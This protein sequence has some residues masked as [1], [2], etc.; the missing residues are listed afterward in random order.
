MSEVTYQHYSIQ[1]FQ[2]NPLIEAL[3]PLLSTREIVR[4]LIERPEYDPKNRQAPQA[5]RL[6]LTQKVT[7][8]YQ[9]SS[10]D[11]ELFQMI[12][13]SL[14]WGY[15]WRNPLDPSYRLRFGK[16]L[17]QKK[18]G[19]Y[20]T[21]YVPTTGGFALLG[22]S[23]LGKTSSTRKIL[24]L[25]PQVVFHRCYEGTHFQETQVVW[26]HMDCPKDGSL[27]GL[28]SA[29]FAEVDRACGTTF[30]SQYAGG[31]R[32]TLDDMMQGMVKV[33][34][35]IHLGIVILD[36]VQNLCVSRTSDNIPLKTLNFVVTM[37]NTINVPVVMVGT[38]RA[39]SFFQ[40]EFQ[41][42]K[43]ASSQG[44]AL[45]ERMEEDQEWDMFVRAMWSYQYTSNKVSLTKKLS[46]MLYEESV[47][48]P[49]LAV[50]I[51]KLVQEKAIAF[52]A[53]TFQGEDF[54]LIA[55][56][57]MGLTKPMA[58]SI[59]SGR[60]INLKSFLDLTP[61]TSED[62]ARLYPSAASS[63]EPPKPADKGTIQQKATATLLGMGLIARDARHYVDLVLARHPD[64]KS[65]AII[66][67][68]AYAEYLKKEIAS[69]KEDPGK[70]DKENSSNVAEGYENN[71]SNGTIG[72]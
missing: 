16:G 50:Q 15:V 63:A 64:C 11:V 59:K 26:V 57:K 7:Q 25:F 32:T 23:G 8:F 54:R 40:K 18:E 56:R 30:A 17:A 42:A 58:E 67:R 69:E 21:P 51:Y 53:E 72:L 49:F 35:S 10:R 55:T 36:E 19:A 38:P 6:M 20:Y 34:A 27:K 3:P 43:R 45:W 41:Q 44:A 47:G 28:C 65:D 12:D 13:R 61:F 29:F 31:K 46:H 48:I 37:I 71:I 70:K 62:Y 14:R 33:A 22:V 9:P 24:S 2:G 66:A 68:E 39:L 60:E 52:D 5:E 4:K 1:D